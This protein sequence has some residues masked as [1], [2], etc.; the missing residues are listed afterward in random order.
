KNDLTTRHVPVCVVSTEEANGRA[1]AL[2]ALRSVTKPLP[3]QAA[4]EGLIDD[5]K[6]FVGRPA[7]TLLVAGGG[8]DDRA[9]VGELLAG[10]D[11]QVTAAG[12]DREAR[13]MLRERRTDCVV[14]L[15]APGDGA[16]VEELAAEARRA[17]PDRAVPV[18]V[19]SE[20][21]PLAAEAAD[22]R[23]H[24]VCSPERLLD[25]VTF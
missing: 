14:L 15:P 4:L 9:R 13:Q 8:P 10:S 1:S 12:S 5:V 19:Y 17:D 25:Q 2:G 21:A 23:V 24:R 6:E 20:G 11:V 7:K 16:D 18:V 3:N 22:G